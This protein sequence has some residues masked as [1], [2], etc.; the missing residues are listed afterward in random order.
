MKR[1]L[2]IALISIVASC[3]AWAQE[4]TAKLASHEKTA[5]SIQEEIK[6]LE[7]ERNEAILR[8][9]AAALD[10][11]TSDSYTLINLQGELRTKVQILE[12]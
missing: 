4:K 12:S 6:N 10:R 11:M 7:A 9:D 3:T 2:L 1:I 8:G 5:G